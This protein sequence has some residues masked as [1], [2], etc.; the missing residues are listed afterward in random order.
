MDKNEYLARLSNCLAAL[1]DEEK[2]NAVEFYE[3]FFNDAGP[4]NEQEVIRE[5][6]APEFVAS[7]LLKDYRELAATP[8]KKQQHQRSPYTSYYQKKSPNSAFDNNK[9]ILIILLV[10]FSPVIF[11]LGVAAFA[12][13]IAICAVIVVLTVAFILTGIGLFAGGIIMIVY[14]FVYLLAAPANSLISLGG[15]LFM[16]GLGIILTVF[17]IWLC[18][19]G[20]PVI[21]N[22]FVSLC[23][24]PFDRRKRV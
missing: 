2:E 9:T 24:M 17:M 21:L 20:L 8:R 7:Q 15:G 12:L 19:K 3:E 22:G 1:P 5:L 18:A 10:L 11:C 14:G 4:E 13:M 16:S 6:G 23:R